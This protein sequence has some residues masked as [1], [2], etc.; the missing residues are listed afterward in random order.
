MR[1][2]QAGWS[3]FVLLV[4]L[5]V[6][7]LGGDPGISIEVVLEAEEVEAGDAIRVGA[8]VENTGSEDRFVLVDGFLAPVDEPVG[9]PPA[10]RWERFVWLLLS[11]LTGDFEVLHVPVGQTRA[12]V[13]ELSV[14]PRMH[15]RFDVVATG[16]TTR[17]VASVRATLMSKITAPPSSGGVLVHGDLYELGSCRV[18]LTDDGHVYEPKGAAAD[19]M[20]DLLDDLY[21]RPDGVTVLGGIL[22]NTVGCI[23]VELDVD[24]Y[25]FDRRPGSPVGYRWRT[26]ARGSSSE[27]YAGPDEEIVRSKRRIKEVLRDLGAT[28]TGDHPR[29][30]REMVAVV[31]TT[32]TS[33]TRIRVARVYEQD[34]ALLVHYRVTKPGPGCTL[35]AVLAQP[36]HLVVLPRFDGEIRFVRHDVSI[37]CDAYRTGVLEVEK[38]LDLTAARESSKKL[39]RALEKAPV[40]TDPR[41]G[42]R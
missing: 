30:R 20:F 31:T 14:H 39:V 32:G 28:P 1:A 35:P 5:A 41:A 16:R 29:F 2:I 27:T 12:A 42:N 33:L 18:L 17:G 4:V 34:G 26:L 8:V 37:R 11:K 19:A 3:A 9:S 22:P 24:L 15:G 21:P 6:P 38:S 10:T 23:G 25:R 7:A 36:Y 40:A 13:L